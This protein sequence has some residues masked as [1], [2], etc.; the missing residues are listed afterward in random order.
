MVKIKCKG[1]FNFAF[2]G[3]HLL[4][5]L[6]AAISSAMQ[7]KQSP[8]FSG[9]QKGEAWPLHCRNSRS[10]KNTIVAG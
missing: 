7:Y 2:M 9:M 3:S 8:K 5:T 1:I 4:L 6:A 10:N